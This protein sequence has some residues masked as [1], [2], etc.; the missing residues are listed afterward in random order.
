M[1]AQEVPATLSTDILLES[2]MRLEGGK[3]GPGATPARQSGLF[4]DSSRGIRGMKYRQ[5]DAQH[6]SQNEKRLRCRGR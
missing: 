1:C 6:L 2:S 4:S 5:P 3:L